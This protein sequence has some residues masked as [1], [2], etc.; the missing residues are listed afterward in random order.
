M[1]LEIN[2]DSNPG[3]FNID[4]K[5]KLKFET[6]YDSMQEVNQKIYPDQNSGIKIKEEIT[7]Y[8]DVK[9]EPPDQEYIRNDRFS[10]EEE[11]ALK[12]IHNLPIEHDTKIKS[13]IDKNTIENGTVVATPA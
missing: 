1:N 6:D 4:E 3:S 13:E 10:A 9:Q 12:I 2:Q 8:F 7:P 11:T 5:I